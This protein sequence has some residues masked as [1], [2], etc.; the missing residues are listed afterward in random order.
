[1]HEARRTIERTLPHA[2]LHYKKLTLDK[3]KALLPSPP[4][5][6][7]RIVSTI[8]IH[9][10]IMARLMSMNTRLLALARTKARE[11]H[12]EHAEKQQNHSDQ[13]CPHAC[14]VVGV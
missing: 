2:A 10:G 11:Q 3:P 12:N 8:V 7:S 14:G 13:N 6:S 4:R 9:A 1:M 5:S